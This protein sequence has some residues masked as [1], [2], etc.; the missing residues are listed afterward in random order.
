MHLDVI[1]AEERESLFHQR[2]DIVKSVT[3]LL[4]LIFTYDYSS[5]TA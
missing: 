1:L 4:D 2:S 5:Q 3:K